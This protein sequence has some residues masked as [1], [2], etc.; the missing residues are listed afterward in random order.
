MIMEWGEILANAAKSGIFA[1]LFTALL[2]FV[3]R[4]AKVREDKYRETIDKL[5]TS[6]NV[7]KEIKYDVKE[8]KR[9]MRFNGIALSR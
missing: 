9:H 4:D 5:C 3:L 2:A 8:I 6:L 1:L 7:V